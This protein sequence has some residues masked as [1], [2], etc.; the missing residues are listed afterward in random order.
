M[1][2]FTALMPLMTDDNKEVP[3]MANVK[4]DR[5]TKFAI[6][7]WTAHSNTNAM[8]NG[9]GEQGHIFAGKHRQFINQDIVTMLGVYIIDG[10]APSPQL[11]QKMQP[12]SKSPIH[13]N[14]RIADALDPGYQQNIV[15]FATSSPHRIR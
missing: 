12:Q 8:L 3:S 4:G 11:L 13:G 1:Y 7:N 2:W 5:R 15:C 6:S 10:L 9:A 14:N